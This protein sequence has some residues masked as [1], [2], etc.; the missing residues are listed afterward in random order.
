[1]KK[2]IG[3]SSNFTG[4]SEF[5]IFHTLKSML[6]LEYK[7][8]PIR[9]LAGNDKDDLIRRKF[10]ALSKNLIIG[11]E[12][13]FWINGNGPSLTIRKGTICP[14]ISIQYD[15]EL[16]SIIEIKLYV[17]SKSDI[18][19]VF[20]SLIKIK[21]AYP[22]LKCLLIIYVKT[23]DPI[24]N[25]LKEYEENYEWFSFR[26]LQENNE[27]ITSILNFINPLV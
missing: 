23:S 8:E 5:L 14:D 21:Q 4:V 16:R 9:E 12:I 20:N 2:S 15:N 25:A 7:I 17:G 27:K 26:I 10:H 13:P 6:G 19:T 11:H 18:E 1:M 22:H 24:K 3:S